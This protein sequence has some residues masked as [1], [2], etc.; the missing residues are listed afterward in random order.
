MIWGANFAN[1]D[2]AKGQNGRK[3]LEILIKTDGD[4]ELFTKHL[5]EAILFECIQKGL[6]DSIS[7]GALFFFFLQKTKKGTHYFMYT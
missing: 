3:L 5:F 1:Y 2:Q 7:R 4:K 6:R